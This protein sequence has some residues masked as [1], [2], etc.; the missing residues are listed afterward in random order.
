[1]FVIP[2]N[3]DAGISG[4]DGGTDAVSIFVDAVAN[5]AT[6]TRRD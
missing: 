1:M 4:A 2:A 6:A 3:P 5:D